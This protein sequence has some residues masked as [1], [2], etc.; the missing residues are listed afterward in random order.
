MKP[1]QVVFGFFIACFHCFFV[2]LFGFGCI[3]WAAQ[4]LF[5][6]PSQPCHGRSADD[7][8]ALCGP[9]VEGEGFLIALGKAFSFFIEFA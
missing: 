3:L 6:E 1:G 4:A 8:C 2:Q 7:V 5:T 9:L